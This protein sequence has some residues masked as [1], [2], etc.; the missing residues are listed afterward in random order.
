MQI[1]TIAGGVGAAR[2][3]RALGATWG[4]SSLTAIVNVADDELVNGLPV[5]PDIDSIL[6]TLAGAN[7]EQRGWGLGGETWQA[8]SML[9][10]YAEANGRSDIGWF[11]LGDL[12]LG[13]HMYRA[14]RLA[15]G[16]ALDV[17]TAEMARAWG[18]EL[19]IVPVTNDRLSTK[20]HTEDGRLDFQEYFVREHH[21]VAVTGV[22]F[23]GT[24]TAT[25]APGVLGSIAGA[26][27]IVIA[28]SNPI[29][30]VGPVLAVRGVR[31][32]IEARR[33]VAVAV[34]PIIGGKALKGPA[35]RL[36]REL[37]HESSALGVARMYVDLVSTM[38]IDTVDADLAPDIEALGMAVV[39]TD[40]IM[41]DLDIARRLALSTVEAI[42]GPAPSIPN[43]VPGGPS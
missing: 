30:S 16:A 40:T 36:L 31:D 21:E 27:V 2:M 10:R 38:V 35:D 39:V 26:D 42:T 14:V 3:L 4:P 19:R 25:A 33:E 8:M 7:D 22:E 13:S 43:T 6:Y 17:V 18:L 41:S 37:G 20:L 28:P 12:D 23:D 34:S 15:E 11:N 32:A 5:S 29:V 24:D 9:R 1:T